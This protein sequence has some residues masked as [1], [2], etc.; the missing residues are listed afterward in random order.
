MKPI[1]PFTAF[2]TS[3][4]LIA[5]VALFAAWVWAIATWGAPVI[6]APLVAFL[7]IGLW[8]IVYDIILTEH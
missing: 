4:I 5:V 3:C 2:L 1:D 7:L 6:L 8:L